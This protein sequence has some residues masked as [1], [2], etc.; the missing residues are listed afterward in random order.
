MI[1]GTPCKSAICDHQYAILSPS[2]GWKV[3]MKETGCNPQGIFALG[4]FYFKGDG[5]DTD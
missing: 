2:R 4:I 3:G 5:D 1:D